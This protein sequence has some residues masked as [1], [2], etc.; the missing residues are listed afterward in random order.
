MTAAAA[1]VVV[2]P[3]PPGPQATTISLVANRPSMEPLPAEVALPGR[4]SPGRSGGGHQ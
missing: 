1:A 2:L 4:G 3:T